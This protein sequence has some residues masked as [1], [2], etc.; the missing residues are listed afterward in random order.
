MSATPGVGTILPWEWSNNPPGPA[1]YTYEVP[2]SLEVQP[3]TSTAT[4]DGTGA[5]G[6]FVPVL[7]LYS[8]TG[9]LLASVFPVGVVMAPGDIAEVTWLPPFGS[10]PSAA[11]ASGGIQYD[12]YPQTGDWLYS[13][14]TDPTGS[15]NGFGTDIEDSG[16]GG[17][18]IQA[19]GTGNVV[20]EA[21]SDSA[22]RLDLF[23]GQ[24]LASALSNIAIQATSDGDEITITVPSGGITIK[25]SAGTVCTVVILTHATDKLG[26]YGNNGVVQPPAPT[27]LAEVIAALSSAGGGC[28]ITA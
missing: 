21:D 18:N 12:T 4:F 22:Q 1:P 2:A 23:A 19:T 9:A 25:D 13:D 14:T 15:P 11:P 24:L 3:Y 26:F 7:S 17:I 6:N 27:T 16:S 8:Q 10:A 28:G 5:G 20:I